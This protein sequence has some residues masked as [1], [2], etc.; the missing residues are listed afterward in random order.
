MLLTAKAPV[1]AALL[2]VLG[3]WALLGAVFH[4]DPLEAEQGHDMLIQSSPLKYKVVLIV[5]DAFRLD[6]YHRFGLM[7][8]YVK[9]HPQKA[10]LLQMKA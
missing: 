7:A 2:L 4:A 9:D 5:L 3:L 10:R 6:Y 1:S 8:K